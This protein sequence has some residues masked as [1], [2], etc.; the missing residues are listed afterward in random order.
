[1]TCQICCETLN[2]KIRKAVECPLCEKISCSKC[3]GTFIMEMLDPHCMF[4]EGGLTMDF[5]CQNSTKSFIDKY[6]EHRFEKK[7]E[8]EQSR[9]PE[10]QEEATRIKFERQRQH[11]M[12]RALLEKKVI[13]AK[14]S[15]WRN[16]YNQRKR[17]KFKTEEINE[18]KAKLDDLYDKLIQKRREIQT[19]GWSVFGDDK[20]KK[21]FVKKCP[22][23]TCRGFLSTLYK[24]GTCE[25]YFCGDCNELKNGRNDEEH[26]CNEETKATYDLLKKD[27]KPGPKC[28][29]II[30]KV[31][32]CSQMWCTQCH[33]AVD[34][35]TG[36][37]EK[38][39]IHNPEYFRYLRENDINIPRN[40]NDNNG[41]C[42]MNNFHIPGIADVRRA[43]KYNSFLWTGWYDYV[44]H[45]RHF[46]TPLALHG[47]QNYQRADYTALRISY[48]MN[49][50]SF[51]QW[52]KTLKMTMKRDELDTERYLILD[53]F[54][55]VISDIFLQF[56]LDRQLETFHTSCRNIFIY[57]Q[58]QMLKVQESFKSKD[59]RFILNTEDRRIST[60]FKVEF[61]E[62]DLLNN[63]ES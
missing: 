15:L 26:V 6:R 2:K 18:A 46:I 37:I 17:N 16:E 33:T 45:V 24:C 10:T 57:T 14:L 63:I 9:L 30:F 11:K 5:V 21:I 39:Y 8:I 29:T 60:Y 44:L 32:G 25:K 59:S 22:D 23:E 47:R 48:L 55:A 49:D 43:V 36:T 38:G 50:I 34:W 56:M 61:Y 28:A 20:E 52:K 12:T 42:G 41:R 27:S 31:D 7:F 3:F 51:D 1:M 35:R 19:L 54:C 58:N 40:P 13:E 53:M 4:C 62:G